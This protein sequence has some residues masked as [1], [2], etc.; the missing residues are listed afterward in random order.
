MIM[1][2]YDVNGCSYMYIIIIHNMYIFFWDKRRQFQKES[3][4][5]KLNTFS[6][7]NAHLNLMQYERP[8]VTDMPW[9]R[10]MPISR[11]TYP[12][13]MDDITRNSSDRKNMITLNLSRISSGCDEAVRSAES[14]MS[15]GATSIRVTCS[16]SSL[17]QIEV[18]QLYKSGVI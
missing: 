3:E 1:R 6:F 5:I 12:V 16:A 9:R 7:L 2:L 13:D 18:T 10:S 14:A 8:A 4:L 11:L 17:K 15:S